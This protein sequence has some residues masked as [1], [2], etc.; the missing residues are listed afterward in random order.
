MLINF[1][2]CYESKEREKVHGMLRNVI[3]HLYVMLYWV[4]KRKDNVHEEYRN[5]GICRKIQVLSFFRK[6][7]IKHVHRRKEP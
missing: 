4:S 2:S 5:E 7:V 6:R 3:G 1:I